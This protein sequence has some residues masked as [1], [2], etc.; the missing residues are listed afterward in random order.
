MDNTYLQAT[1]DDSRL[2]SGRDDPWDSLLARARA[3]R[4]RLCGDGPDFA[5]EPAPAHDLVIRHVEAGRGGSV[6]VPPFARTVDLLLAHAVEVAFV[7]EATALHSGA[8]RDRQLAD[9]ALSFAI[10]VAGRIVEQS[11]KE[12]L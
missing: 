12:S 4:G 11:T 6:R 3:R 5:P 7:A 1:R 10:R 9:D 8:P 2:A